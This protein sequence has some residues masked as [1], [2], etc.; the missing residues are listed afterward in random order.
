VTSASLPLAHL[1]AYEFDHLPPGTY[2]IT[3]SARG[4][5]PT[6]QIVSLVAGTRQALDLTLAAPAQIH[7]TIL[8]AAGKPVPHAEVRL[9]LA[10]Q[11]PNTSVRTVEADAAGAYAFDDLDAPQTYVVEYDYPAGSTPRASKTVT[12]TESQN[13][14][15]DLRPDV[16]TP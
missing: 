3:V 4:A 11:Y 15:V 1:G 9:Y 16:S 13:L 6:S 8:D 14:Q 5:R 2:T 10:S 12:L 7:G